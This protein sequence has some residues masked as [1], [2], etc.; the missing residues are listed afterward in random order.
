MANMSH[1]RFHNTLQDL[2]DCHS[3][4]GEAES[5]SEKKAKIKLIELCQ[6]IAA[7]YSADDVADMKTEL[8]EEIETANRES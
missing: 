8:Q 2:R 5:V 7:E 6:R 4:M 1:C 3:N